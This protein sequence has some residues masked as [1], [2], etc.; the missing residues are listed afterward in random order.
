MHSL[1]AAIG[2]DG[3]NWRQMQLRTLRHTANHIAL[4]PV[5]SPP[6][7]LYAALIGCL[8]TWPPAWRPITHAQMGPDPKRQIRAVMIA[9]LGSLAPRKEGC[10]GLWLH[11]LCFALALLCSALQLMLSPRHLRLPP[12]STTVKSR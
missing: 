6:S 2:H 11:R 8:A 1:A 3:V 5:W 4:A 7:P 9:L 10:C 12:P